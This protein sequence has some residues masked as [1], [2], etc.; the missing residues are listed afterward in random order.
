MTIEDAE[1]AWLAEP[2][3]DV[4][5]VP[6]KYAVSDASSANW[7]VRR[8]VGARGYAS[9]VRAWAATEIRRA[10][11]EEQFFLHQYGTQL[12]QWTR[13]EI[14]ATGGRRRSIGLPGGTVGFRRERPHL[15]ICDE[16]ELLAWCRAH[17]ID[18]C[19]VEVMATGAEALQLQQWSRLNTPQAR[20]NGSIVKSLLDKYLRDTGECP[21][22]AEIVGNEKFYIK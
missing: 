11:R 14:E 19:K 20:L 7:L 18:A 5:D 21:A 4:P 3:D 1:S 22:G 2:E 17:L 8:I 6:V 15:L 10:E 9:R 16:T 12:E 13:A